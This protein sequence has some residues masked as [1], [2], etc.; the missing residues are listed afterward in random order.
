MPLVHPTPPRWPLIALRAALP[1]DTV[2]DAIVGDLHEEFVQDAA[3]RGV[4]HARALYWRRALGVIV[5]ATFDELRWRSWASGGSSSA[6]SLPAPRGGAARSDA[7]GR[8]LASASRSRATAN[9][10]VGAL[11]FGVLGVGIVVNT[12]LFANV[13]GA[14]HGAGHAV[15]AMPPVIAVGAT[16]LAVV[17][18]GTAAV[19][20]CAGPRWLRRRLRRLPSCGE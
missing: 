8:I 19:V 4:P 2:G 14:S 9:A 3:S 17:C 5:H 16:V 15:A 10:G 11:A 12:L 7:A 1:R 20:L 6:E 13:R 18:A